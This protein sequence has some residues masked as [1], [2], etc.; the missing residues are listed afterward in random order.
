MY[1]S[2]SGSLA[3]DNFDI[4]MMVL[5]P[6]VSYL[7]AETF[8]ISGLLA[9]M[10]C[11]FLQSLYAQ[12]NLDIE[13]SNLFSNTI[14]ALS[15][16]CRSICD[17]IIGIALPLNA[18]PFQEIGVFTLIST[19]FVIFLVSYGVSQATIKKCTKRGSI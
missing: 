13:R 12:Q 18:V 6:I 2:G 5:S 9:I 4:L 3:I 19:L 14:K 7:M 11:G 1:Q 8:S 10:C 16:S 17:I 15:Y